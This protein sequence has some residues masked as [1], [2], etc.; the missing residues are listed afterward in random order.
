MP[1]NRSAIGTPILV[2]ST[3]PVMLISPPPPPRG[4]R[5]IPGATPLRPVVPESGDRQDH[6]T[7]VELMHLLDGEPEPV[8]HTWPEVL[9]QYVGASDQL[10]Q[11]LLA[12]G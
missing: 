1:A 5:V 11:E 3:A 6:Q 8:Q 2:G 10:R 9:H 12:L 7:G 4:D